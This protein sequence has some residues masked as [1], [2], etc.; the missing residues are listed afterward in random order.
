ME[1]WIQIE[2]LPKGD[3]TSCLM[4]DLT[5]VDM[6]EIYRK[7]GKPFQTH[8]GYNNGKVMIG[9]AATEFFLEQW[10]IY[11]QLQAVAPE[12]KAGLIEVPT[13]LGRN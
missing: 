5:K 12:A 2:L 1:H 9:E 11:K 7:G 10:G 6:V 4:M 8:I 3:Q 13:D